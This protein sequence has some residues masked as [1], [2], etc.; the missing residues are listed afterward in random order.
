MQDIRDGKFEKGIV[1]DVS[2]VAGISHEPM[3]IETNYSWLN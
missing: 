2:A 3:D 1:R